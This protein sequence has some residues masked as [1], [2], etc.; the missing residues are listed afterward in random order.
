LQQTRKQLREL[1]M[2]VQE[3][4]HSLD[5]LAAERDACKSGAHEAADRS[6]VHILFFWIK[7]GLRLILHFLLQ[8]PFSLPVA[9]E[10]ADGFEGKT[11]TKR[12]LD[13]PA[14]L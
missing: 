8:F 4:Q 1:E 13:S 5:Q 14:L 7:A 10:P 11:V 9:A 2:G 6:K 12:S 3:Q